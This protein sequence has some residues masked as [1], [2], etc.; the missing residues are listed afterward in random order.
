MPVEYIV[1]AFGG[2][3]RFKQSD[4]RNTAL[5]FSHLFKA[6]RYFESP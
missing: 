2:V 6:D 5:L 1:V 3:G 4:P